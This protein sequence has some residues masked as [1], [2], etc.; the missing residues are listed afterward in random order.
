MPAHI[1]VTAL[2]ELLG[3]S[4][5]VMDANREKLLEKEAERK[6][7]RGQLLAKAGNL[8]VFNDTRRNLD[9]PVMRNIWTAP[10][11]IIDDDEDEEYEFPLPPLGEGETEIVSVDPGFYLVSHWSYL[12]SEETTP[13]TS[14]YS[15][16]SFLDSTGFIDALQWGP[17]VQI[18]SLQVGRALR[19]YQGG[20][21]QRAN[22]GTSLIK[23]PPPSRSIKAQG[24]GGVSGPYT[25]GEI[26]GILAAPPS[27]FP[28]SIESPIIRSGFASVPPLGWEGD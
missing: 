9:D 17:S 1:T 6:A 16:Q 23:N 22:Y 26:S 19:E 13:P 27:T 5:E 21:F 25:F 20:L 24:V 8:A 10:A 15:S 3:R 12:F 11:R 2:S 14:P 4:Q 18:N 28:P 7:E